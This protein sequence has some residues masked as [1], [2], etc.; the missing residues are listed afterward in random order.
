MSYVCDISKKQNNFDDAL[1]FFFLKKKCCSKV[2]N[3]N[4]SIISGICLKGTDLK[5][6]ET[7]NK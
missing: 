3:A 2:F 7:F 6:D 1:A 5:N 4:C